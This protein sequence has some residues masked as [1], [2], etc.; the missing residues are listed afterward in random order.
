MPFPS[1]PVLFIPSDHHNIDEPFDSIRGQHGIRGTFRTV[2]EPEPETTNIST[3]TSTKHTEVR[4]NGKVNAS[5]APIDLGTWSLS[6]CAENTFYEPVTPI[7]AYPS[8]Y[9]VQLPL[10][11]PMPQSP[12][13]NGS[14]SVYES[15]DQKTARLS[16]PDLPIDI[17]YVLT[18]HAPV[19]VLAL[20]A[21]TC[22]TFHTTIIPLLYRD[23]NLTYVAPVLPD[24]TKHYPELNPMYDHA[25]HQRAIMETLVENP[26]LAVNIKTFSFTLGLFCSRKIDAELYAV[27][28]LLTSV[29]TLAI[30]D[31]PSHVYP[32]LDSGLDTAAFPA[33]KT[34]KLRGHMTFYL[35]STIL[36][37]GRKDALE[38]VDLDVELH[39]VPASLKP[40]E[41]RMSKS[42]AG[43]QH[44]VEE[45]MRK[46]KG[47]KRVV[48]GG[49]E[50]SV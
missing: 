34:V 46:S 48:V 41:A 43:V 31:M 5:L 27:F 7:T 1:S 19:S 24:P 45:M 21:A 9:R 15:A 13:T 50:L 26:H 36:T 14:F 37:G 16:L 28:N 42:E 11:Y 4:T 47:L 35:A 25:I 38:S 29:E 39:D 18:T 49:K 10:S 20:L 30:D 6:A 33:L 8:K 2:I 22:R 32:L 40:S 12:T 3:S 44:L 17:F 23:I